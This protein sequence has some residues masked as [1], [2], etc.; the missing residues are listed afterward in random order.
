M[1]SGFRVDYCQHV[2]A[3][4]DAQAIKMFNI[5]AKRKAPPKPKPKGAKQHATANIPPEH[6]VCSVLSNVCLPHDL[7]CFTPELPWL[8]DRSILMRVRRV[9]R[10]KKLNSLTD[11]DI[12]YSYNLYVVLDQLSRINAEADYPVGTGN[13]IRLTPKQLEILKQLV[14]DNDEDLL[15]YF[16]EY[17]EKSGPVYIESGQAWRAFC[18]FGAMALDVCS[19]SKRFADAEGAQEKDKGDEGDEEGS[20]E[21]DDEEGGAGEEDEDDEGEGKKCSKALADLIV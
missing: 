13:K 20:A 21:D 17:V 7:R 15:I 11:K 3:F 10:D 16:E 5:E 19:R 18:R 14:D 2:D 4:C 8:A 9:Q 1:C 12:V 6:L